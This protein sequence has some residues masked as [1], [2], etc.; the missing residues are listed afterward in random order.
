MYTVLFDMF[1]VIA[2]HQSDRGKARLA[3]V[4][5]NA[6]QAFWEAYW[7]LR[8]PY[9]RGEVD[10]RRYW[11]AVARALGTEFGATQVT[12]L[13]TADL[14]SWSAVDDTMVDLVNELADAGR[15]IALLSNIPEDLAVHYEGR[16][17][18]LKRFPFLPALA[19]VTAPHQPKPRLIIRL[20]G[21]VD[22]IVDG[23][24]DRGLIT[25]V[26]VRTHLEQATAG[27]LLSPGPGKSSVFASP[28]GRGRGGGRSCPTRC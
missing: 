3:A 22:D 16:Y 7:Q 19:S 9:D 2:R 23:R 1:G 17:A 18:W 26:H 25:A 15:D 28:S 6:T 10:G 21:E 20:N 12:D 4:A 5:G 24:I 14:A 13:I 8:P 11:R 27:E